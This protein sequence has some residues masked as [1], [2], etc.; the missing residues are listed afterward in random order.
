MNTPLRLTRRELIKSGGALIVG[1]NFLP[2]SFA[3]PTSSAVAT[4]DPNQLDSWLAIHSD[5]TAT[6]YIGFAELG[7]GCSTALLQVAAEELDLGLD[8]MRVAPL[9]TGTSPNQGGTYSSSAMRRGAPQVQRAAA[10]ARQ[11]LLTLAAEQLFLPASRLRVENGIVSG[12]G[13]DNAFTTYGDL[14][15]DRRFELTIGGTAPLKAPNEYKL[16]GVALPRKDLAAKLTGTYPYLQHQRLPGMLHGRIVRPRG[17]GAYRD[18]VRLVSVREDSINHIPG[19]RVLRQG[20]FLGVVAPREWDAVRAARDLE[21]SWERPENLPGNAGLFEKMLSGPT[22]DRLV[23]EEGDVTAITGVAAT[24]SFAG[25]SPYQAHA[26]FAPNCAVAAV[27]DDSVLLMCASQDI[28]STR[29]NVAALLGMAPEQVR[30]QYFESSGTFGHSCWDDAAQAAVLLS[31]LAGAPVRVQF[32]RWDEHGWDTYGPAHVGR[33]RA[34]ADAEGKLLSYEYEGWQHHWSLIETTAQ[35]ATDTP[36]SEWPAM[37]A[38]QINPLVLGGMYR[39]PNLKLVN[40]HVDG[41][42]YLKGA[43][44]RSPLDLSFCFISEQGIDDLAHQLGIDPYEFRRRNIADERWL[45]VL[46]AAAQAAN[47]EPRV[48]ASNLSQNAVVRGRG[49]GLGTHLASWGGAVAEIEVNRT[50]GKVR[51]LH[52]VGAIDAGRVVNPANVENQ[53]IGQ[54]VQTASRMLLEEVTFD[55]RGVTSLD[56]ASYPILRMQDCPRITPVIVQRLQE[57]PSGAGE[58]VMAAAAAAIANAF[59]DAT[60][61]RLHHYPF[62]SERVLAA[63]A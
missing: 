9:A 15:G 63:L 59:F 3:Q 39:I 2:Q 37:A 1:F 7:Q 62:T 43:W 31:K 28:Y 20:N 4:P 38:Q 18:G 61:R 49:I 24:T 19:A 53:I 55:T 17:Q 46:D 8:Q 36:A 34:S 42:D 10:E 30:V 44:L 50:T 56:W 48:A 21:V 26:P 12:R 14:I 52:L 57:E 23:R 35:S 5:N 58:E 51:I 32:M 47:W 27:R 60:G 13:D 22:N 25:T 11:V 29:N 16:V 45:G 54:L 41:L 40:H 33:M 6:L